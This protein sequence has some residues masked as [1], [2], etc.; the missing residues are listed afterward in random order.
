MK[1]DYAVQMAGQYIPGQARASTTVSRLQCV[2]AA[3]EHQVEAL[4]REEPATKV[5]L[6]TFNDEVTVVGDGSLPP[7]TVAGDRLS[8]WTELNELGDTLSL[9][10]PLSESKDGL[11]EQMW[12][13]VEHGGTALGPALLLSIALAGKQ[14]GSHVVL[15]TDGKANVGIGSLEDDE[16]NIN[17]VYTQLAELAK[18][19]GVV[20]SVVSII[21]SECKLDH[22]GTVATETNGEVD[23]VNPEE[24]VKQKGK[25]SCLVNKPVLAYGA[26]AMVILHRALQ[27]HGEMDDE[28]EVSY[29]PRW[30]NLC[31]PPDC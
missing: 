29:H 23:R 21:G 14:P 25:L 27:F 4:H 17:L 13:V 26:M 6:I 2:Q 24:L 22:L 3:I 1:K 10:E 28:S 11:L 7:I 16:D 9:H 18:V 12:D 5:G 30:I 19:M 31:H 8:S 15:C 20:V